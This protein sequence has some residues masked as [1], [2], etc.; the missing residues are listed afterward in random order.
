MHL[1]VHLENNMYM[2]FHLR[3]ITEKANNAV[4]DISCIIKKIGWPREARFSSTKALVE[5]RKMTSLKIT[6]AEVRNSSW[7][8]GNEDGML[9]KG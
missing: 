1:F 4:G 9:Q 8:N 3:K 2:G 6:K 5:E 7:T